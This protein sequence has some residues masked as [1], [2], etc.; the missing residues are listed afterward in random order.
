[1]DNHTLAL[2]PVAAQRELLTVP[3]ARRSIWRLILLVGVGWIALVPAATAQ[4]SA[5]VTEHLVTRTSRDVN[6]KESVDEKVI[7]RTSRTGER[8]D[9]VIEIYLPSIEADRLT[10]SRRIHR[11]TTSADEG[12]QTVEECEERSP[13]GQGEPLRVVK[14]SVTTVRKTG[15]DA[16]VSDRR[17]FDRDTNGRLMPV[18]TDAATAA[19][20]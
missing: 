5:R 17:E 8:E 2:T 12:T 7:T 16:S 11:V 3:R 4:S 10:L 9:V 19:R 20:Q 1:M 14:R 13:A 6:G 15:P 18:I